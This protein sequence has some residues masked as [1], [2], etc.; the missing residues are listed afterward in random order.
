MAKAAFA[1]AYRPES[2]AI[3]SAHRYQRAPVAKGSDFGP[4]LRRQTIDAPCSKQLEIDL[5]SS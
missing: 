4:N 1:A 3:R 2:R 5:V